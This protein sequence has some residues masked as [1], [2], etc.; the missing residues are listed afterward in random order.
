VE[1]EAPVKEAEEFDKTFYHQS[2]WRAAGE[3]MHAYIIRRN[4][5]FERLNTTV[6]GG[7]LVPEKLQAH[8][9]LKFCGLN[10]SERLN[11]LSS[12]GNVVDKSAF[13][14]ALRMQHPT[15]HERGK[16]TAKHAA[17]GSKGGGKHGRR[18]PFR[19]TSAT[20]SYMAEDEHGDDM[21]FQAEY[22]EDHVSTMSAEAAAAEYE[23][24]AYL[25]G[26]SEYA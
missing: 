10:R 8:L 1:D 17:P 2:V 24:Q 6:E 20:S 19:R 12:C 21:A 22:D 3:A 13:E 26:G 9:L 7:C 4:Q 11:I 18:P 5:E 15:I 14:K 25:Q 16:H 23:F